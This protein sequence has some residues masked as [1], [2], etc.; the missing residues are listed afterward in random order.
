MIP[1]RS[2]FRMSGLRGELV[3][4]GAVGFIVR[5]LAVLAG[6][7]SSVV[8]ARVLGPSGYGVYAY[9]LAIVSILTLP[10]Q[11][12]LPTLV[13]RE[14]AR[15][16]ATGDWP[17]IRG[18]WIWASR[19]ILLASAGLIGAVAFWL[20]RVDVLEP[21][22]AKTLA[23]GLPL[24]PLLAIAAVRGAALLG[25]RKIFWSTFPDQVFRPVLLACMVAAAA[26]AGAVDAATAMALYVIA[27]AAAFIIGTIA[28]WRA[29]PEK[30]RQTRQY[31][32][33]GKE[34]LQALVPLSLIVGSQIINQ[35]TDLLILGIFRSS[36]EVGHYRVALSI[37]TLMVFGLVAVYFV[38]QP[39]LVNAHALGQHHRLQ[40]LVSA[41]AAISTIF[42]FFALIAIWVVGKPVINLLFGSGFTPAHA[43]LVVLSIAGLIHAIFGMA[44]GTL[45]MTGKERLIL[46]VSAVAALANIIGNVVLIPKY[47]MIGAASA[48]A[49]S[50][51]FAEITKYF[52]ALRYVRIDCTALG[53]F[54]V[55]KES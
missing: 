36:E 11:M 47:G 45:T 21:D 27:A 31:Q 49:L 4:G 46:R 26:L 22:Q 39:Y 32:T 19:V 2:Y 28:L 38:I 29:R 54:R 48:T 30:L 15:A 42:G 20:W 51:T 5:I 55:R 41:A 6:L 13:I 3:R 14:T 16:A 7:F 44:G 50:I 10:V 18:M 34:W 35:N 43:P 8:L 33:K 23:W 25:L 1:L 17:L 9:A 52:V 40:K 24:I 12:G 37:N 53:I